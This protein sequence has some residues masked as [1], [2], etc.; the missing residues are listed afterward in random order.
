[1]DNASDTGITKDKLVEF[2]YRI[3]DEQGDIREQVDLPLTYI[4]GRE[5]GMYPKIEQALEGKQVGDE[6]VVELTPDDG[7]GDHDPGMLFEDD[8]QNVPPEYR[9]IGAEAEFHNDRGEARTFRVTKIENGRITLDGNHPLAG[10]TI[11]FHLNILAIRDA[12]ADE[13]SGA[14][15]TGQAANSPT[16]TP[17]TL[18]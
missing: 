9:M 17:P 5:S 2:T 8:L 12:T 13:L 4:H 7:F 16:D 15:P 6:V 14:V 10:Q 3:V 18:N 11:W 1:M